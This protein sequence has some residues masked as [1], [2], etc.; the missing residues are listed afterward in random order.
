MENL[1]SKL[2]ELTNE[3]WKL[4]REALD[5]KEPKAYHALLRVTEV[6]NDVIQ[7]EDSQEEAGTT[8]EEPESIP[9]FAQHNGEK[10]EAAF[11]PKRV[12]RYGHSDCV[13]FEDRFRTASAAAKSITGYNVNGWRFW[14]Y[15]RS[16]GSTGII[17]QLR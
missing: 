3:S 2:K 6:L 10:V 8:T 7:D 4:A 12:C 17:D 13:Q 9:I 16:D 11:H 15:R 5:Q 1:Q 14:R